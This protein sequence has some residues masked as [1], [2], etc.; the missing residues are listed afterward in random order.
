MKRVFAI[1]LCLL[2]ILGIL[3]GCMNED[4][5]YYN[6]SPQLPT[7]DIPLDEELFGKP[8]E[9]ILQNPQTEQNDQESK[10][11]PSEE[12]VETPVVNCITCN[13][14][15]VCPSCGG[16][17]WCKECKGNGVNCPFCLRDGT[18]GKCRNCK[19]EIYLE[20]TW[21]DGDWEC[22]NC[23]AS[24][25]CRWC[26]GEGVC[27]KCDGTLLIECN[28]CDGEGDCFMCD[29]EG[30]KGGRKCRTCDGSGDCYECHGSKKREC[31]YCDA[32]PGKCLQCLGDG[33]CGECGGDGSTCYKCGSGRG[34]VACYYCTGNP[35][36]CT[37]CK[38]NYKDC[39]SC[40]G[41][42]ELCKECTDGKCPDCGG[43]YANTASDGK[44]NDANIGSNIG[45]GNCPMCDG[46]GTCKQCGG[47]GMC[48]NWDCIFG[49][50]LCSNCEGGGNC[51]VC[52]G[53]GEDF[54][55]GTKCRAAYCNDGDCTKCERG[56]VK[57][58]TCGGDGK[59]T[60][61]YCEDGWCTYCGGDGDY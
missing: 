22:D 47:V 15:G 44:Q 7:Q 18:K 40:G 28:R 48:P 54:I 52:G 37:Y 21:C 26:D 38:G 31:Y 4:T 41:K 60:A 57:C 13:D 55:L 30:T 58:S 3:S 10:P 35:G 61:K 11:S 27:Y 33:D 39:E 43:K 20:C 29:G 49:E 51:I 56:E 36:K 32:R 9:P 25:D 1:S 5:S 16:N 46:Y 2:M 50:V 17:K 14:M 34:Y 24:G 53:L 6:D 42:G 12:A 23:D 19:G 8:I 45:S 59:C